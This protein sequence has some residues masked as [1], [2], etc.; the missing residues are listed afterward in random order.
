MAGILHHPPAPS[1]EEEGEKVDAVRKAPS[2]LEEGVGG[3]GSFKEG[4]GG[5]GAP[6]MTLRRR[7]TR[8]R[9]DPT[10]PEKRLWGALRN[11]RLNGYKF[12]RQKVIGTRIVDFFCPEKGLIVEVDGDTHDARTDKSRDAAMLAE[13]GFRT[14]RVTNLEVMQ[15]IEGVLHVILENIRS[16]PDRWLNRNSHHPPAPSSE[17]EG[18]KSIDAAKAPSFS[19]KGEKVGAARKAPSSSEEGVGGGGSQ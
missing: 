17:E 13:Y 16:T 15:N 2:S 11:S 3:G 18:E 9:S 12:R 14:V 6:G 19:E 10:E 8:M 7:A 5:G 1:S 4:V